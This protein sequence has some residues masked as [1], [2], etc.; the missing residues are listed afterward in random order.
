MTILGKILV[1]VNLVFSLVTGALIV[2]VFVTRTNWKASYDDLLRKYEARG[3]TV[4][5]YTKQ[6]D[7]LREDYNRD[8]QART[9]Q[10]EQLTA[11]R[12]QVRNN[13]TALETD[14]NNIEARAKKAEDGLAVA[15]R[16]FQGREQEV[17]NYQKIVAEKDRR[18]N[19]QENQL[20]D[21]RDRAVS[22]EIA[23]RSEHQRN[24][25]LL[26][27][28]EKLSR[29]NEKLQAR[30]TSGGAGS[31]GANGERRVPIEDLKG[32]VLETDSSGLVT[33]SLGSDS[34]LR[35]GDVLEV[36]R[37]DPKP[38]YVGTVRVVDT[39][40]KHAV[41]RPVMPLRAGPIQKDDIVASRI[42]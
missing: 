11:E 34:G 20:R 26:D 2:M 31:K 37:L 42:R 36:Y 33:I 4:D 1:I 30:V 14:K 19:D 3:A 23:Q 6:A 25:L 28:I 40:F 24:I 22:A 35:V 32:K 12:E 29:D 15:T 39:H 10:I 21:F 17:Q 7:L 9:K 27:Q 8:L 16:D 5:A 41:A 13:L 18:L 38:D